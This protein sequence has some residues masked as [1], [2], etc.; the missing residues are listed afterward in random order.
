MNPDSL[1]AYLAS[2]DLTLDE[3]VEITDA[4]TKSAAIVDPAALV[5]A[6][7]PYAFMGAMA[8][9]VGGYQLGKQLAKVMDA[10]PADVKQLQLDELSAQMRAQIAEL[11]ARDEVKR[12]QQKQNQSMAVS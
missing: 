1:F 8:L 2:N 4:C 10:G 6:V 3:A 9:P 11:K 7:G 12:Q 5:N